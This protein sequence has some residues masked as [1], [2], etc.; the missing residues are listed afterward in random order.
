MK[1]KKYINNIFILIIIYAIFTIQIFGQNI[2]DIRNKIQEDFSNTHFAAGF[3]E[4]IIM[5]DETELSGAHYEIDDSTDNTSNTKIRIVAIPFHLRFYPWNDAITGIYI[6]GVI[7]YGKAS[8]RATDIYSGRHPDLETS[9]D[10]YW[11]TLGGLIGIGPEFIITDELKMN[12]IINGG[13]AYIRSDA[14]YKGP[15][16]PTSQKILDGMIFNWSG[17]TAIWGGAIKFNWFHS[18]GRGYELEVVGR[19]DIRWTDTINSDNYIQE[20]SSHIQPI[21]LRTDLVGPTCL[22]LFS[23]RLYWRALAGYRYF[24]DG[25]IFGTRQT[26]LLGGG[27]EYDIS[28]TIPFA[29]RLHTRF[30]LIF[31]DNISGYTIGAGLSF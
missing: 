4:L 19:Y 5:A 30:G 3:S 21:T 16:A 9:A 14:D 23:R 15:G 13:I 17:W 26:I 6:E 1:D 29:T 18:L 8:Q 10:N 12:L 7:G 27:L 2:D 25:S 28:D 24:L 20:F 31:G 11:E 22:T